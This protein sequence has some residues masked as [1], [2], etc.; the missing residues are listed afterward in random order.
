MR[1]IK[2]AKRRRGAPSEDVLEDKSKEIKKL[3]LLATHRRKRRQGL[4][5]AQGGYGILAI[6]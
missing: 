5:R 1:K 3:V 4:G 6:D 2:A